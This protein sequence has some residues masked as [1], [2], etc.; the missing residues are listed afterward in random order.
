MVRPVSPA[1]PI[2][3]ASARPQLSREFLLVHRR[4]RFAAAAAELAHEFGVR[5]ITSTLIVQ[6]AKGSRSGFYEAFANVEDCLRFAVAEAFEELFEPV[7]ATSSVAGWAAQLHAAVTGFCVAA[8][9]D[10]VRAELFL[11]HSRSLRLEAGEGGLADGVLAFAPIFAAARDA[12][13]AA[14][15]MPESGEELFGWT[16]MALAARRVLAGRAEALTEDAEALVFLL[17][18]YFTSAAGL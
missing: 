9:A 6:V 5:A 14:N 12:T 10:P 18:L 7:R 1:R 17:E 2:A 16:I 8:A 11:V 15:L 13:G 4:R 3:A